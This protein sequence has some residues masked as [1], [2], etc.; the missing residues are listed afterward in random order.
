[1]E[2]V[3]I[4]SVDRDDLA[5]LGAGHWAQ[6]VRA[7]KEPGDVRVEALVPDFRCRVAC[8]D[9]VAIKGPTQ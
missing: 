5:D 7:V 3:V 6:T 4:T 9:T 2:F 8:L 1:M